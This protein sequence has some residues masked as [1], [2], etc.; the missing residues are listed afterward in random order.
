MPLYDFRCP[1]CAGIFER[2]LPMSA[3]DGAIACTYCKAAFTAVPIPSGAPRVKVN[4]SW[5]PST[6]AEF[7]TGKKAQG[8]GAVSGARRS[9]VL[10]V[11]K[12]S[13]CS[14]CGA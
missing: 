1:H 5:R 6:Q 12:G 3:L 14:L 11:C 13:D 10:H 2:L 4:A 7:L 8:P 9:N